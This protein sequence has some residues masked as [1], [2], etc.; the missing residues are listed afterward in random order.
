MRS[1]TCTGSSGGDRVDPLALER[2][3]KMLRTGL[4]EQSNRISVI[5]AQ[6]RD[7]LIALRGRR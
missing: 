1:R 5:A 6:L 3:L 2:Q 7:E 4:Y